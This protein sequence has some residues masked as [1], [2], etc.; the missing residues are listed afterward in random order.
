[1]YVSLPG[2]EGTRAFSL[3]N[4]PNVS[5]VRLQVKL[6]EGGKGTTYIHETLNEGDNFNFSGPYGRFIVRK[7]EKKPVLF[8]AAGTGV[9]SPRSMIKDLLSEGYPESI[10]LFYGPR[11][12]EELYGHSEYLNWAA[13]YPQF[14][15]VPVLSREGEENG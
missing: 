8:F 15:Y 5:E 10:T 14:K 3:A 4:S 7:S 6:V 11:N 2:I 13:E 12:Q 1:M 9:S